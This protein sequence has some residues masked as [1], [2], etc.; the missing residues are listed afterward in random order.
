MYPLGI[1]LFFYGILR[2][3]K[4]PEMVRKKRNNAILHEVIGK[5]KKMTSQTLTGRIA[6]YVGGNNHN[7]KMADQR[8]KQMFKGASRIE[9]VEVEVT[10]P[11]FC[12]YLREIGIRGDHEEDIEDLVKAFDADFNGRLDLTE[13]RVSGRVAFLILPKMIQKILELELAVTGMETTDDITSQQ[14]EALCRFRCELQKLGFGGRGHAVGFGVWGSRWSEVFASQEEAEEGSNF[15]KRFTQQI[16]RAEG[17][18]AQD[19]P[20]NQRRSSNAFSHRLKRVDSSFKRRQHYR[21]HQHPSTVSLHSEEEDG[22]SHVCPVPRSGT[23]EA[24]L[25]WL[26]GKGEEMVFR[27]ILALPLLRWDGETEEEQ[28]VIDRI[29][30]LFDACEYHLCRFAFVSWVF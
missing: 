16:Q 4:I 19:V 22:A 9:G 30:F 20:K 7:K 1:P 18:S 24:K 6:A 29:G 12:E 28:L 11:R 8:S 14:L 3:F 10:G 27:G 25:K 21:R 2:I 23:R 26:L 13:F 5:Y 15:T 17:G